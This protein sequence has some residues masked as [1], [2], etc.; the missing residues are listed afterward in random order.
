MTSERAGS[1]KS[2]FIEN[3]KNEL[4]RKYPQM[5]DAIIPVHGPK[6]T[7][8]SIVESL[9][10]SFGGNKERSQAII[11]H[12]DIASS[13]SNIITRSMLHCYMYPRF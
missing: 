10:E 9:I 7:N 5:S 3:M 6:V 2:L 1:G 13:V 11:F 12:L 4:R 8:D